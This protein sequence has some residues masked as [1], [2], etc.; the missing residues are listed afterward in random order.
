MARDFLGISA[1]KHRGSPRPR[2]SDIALTWGPW[3]ALSFLLLVVISGTATHANQDRFTGRINSIVPG[4]GVV[5]IDRSSTRDAEHL[6]A[7]DF[8]G[9]QVVRVW[10]D[11]KNPAT[12][13][14]QS[15]SLS[16]W[17]AGTFVIVVGSTGPTGRVRA[18][19]IEIPKA[20]AAWP[21]SDPSR[22]D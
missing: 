5:V 10:R 16:R 14:E 12:W 11:G 2:S 18:H 4:D 6:V 21:S 20:D 9:A 13:R 22:R 1:R 17:P 8:R 7:V 19:R 3:F 15:T